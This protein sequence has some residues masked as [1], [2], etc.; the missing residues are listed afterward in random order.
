MRTR[1][2]TGL[3]F[4]LGVLVF[5]LVGPPV[6]GIVAWLAMGAPLARSPLPFITG[7]YPEGGALGAG[8]GVLTGVGALLRTNSVLVP[9]VAALLVNVLMFAVTAEQDFAS[10][11]YWVAAARVARVFLPPSLA[12][13][14][15][16][17]FLT[18]RLFGG[19]TND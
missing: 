10:P 12:A 8:V 16:C 1:R 9:V 17:W 19:S 13:A 3:R 2:S 18:R 6:G 14:I 7:A 11:A 15:V 5:A 4:L